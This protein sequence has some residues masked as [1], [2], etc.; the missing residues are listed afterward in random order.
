MR[1]I[2]RPRLS[3]SL[4]SGMVGAP[5]VRDPAEQRSAASALSEILVKNV[6]I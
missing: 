3:Y 1:A 6:E 5:A 2:I 4:D